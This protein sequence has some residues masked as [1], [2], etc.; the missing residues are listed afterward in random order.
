MNESMKRI[1]QRR[2]I[3]NR[4]S[5]VTSPIDTA[6]KQISK[7]NPQFREQYKA[8]VEADNAMRQVTG[9]D[10]EKVKKLLK[11]LRKNNKNHYW[12]AVLDSAAK[13]NNFA[14]EIVNNENVQNLLVQRKEDFK[15][16]Y[17][18]DKDYKGR[19]VDVER[20]N[21]SVRP[22]K[23]S[24]IHTIKKEAFIGN[25][26]RRLTDKLMSSLN[27][28][29]E[30]RLRRAMNTLTSKGETLARRLMQLYKHLDYA[31]A[32]GDIG[33]YVNAFNLFKKDYDAFQNT[34][35]NIYNSVKEY[36]PEI[37]S[38]IDDDDEKENEVTDQT[39]STSDDSESTETTESAE[40]TESVE[41][42]ETSNEGYQDQEIGEQGLGQQQLEP[43]DLVAP[44]PKPPQAP[45]QQTQQQSQED[46]VYTS[47]QPQE[48]QEEEFTLPPAEPFDNRYS[49]A[50]KKAIASGEYGIAVAILSKYSQELENAGDIEGSVKVLSIAQELF[51]EK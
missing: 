48:A 7:I 27:D 3:W 45:Q 49:F 31:R 37:D 10:G 5:P 50:A 41:N 20:I 46:G 1:A 15:D 12:L 22:R 14:A 43:L 26:A 6:K 35:N 9:P 8:L 17:F 18:T 11:E 21:E 33:G 16:F 44:F 2:S 13:I 25:L 36:L 34:Y 40:E 47:V 30:K 51:N 4:L 29:E 38:V 42:V 24:S 39:D 19:S 28:T 32:K 23:A